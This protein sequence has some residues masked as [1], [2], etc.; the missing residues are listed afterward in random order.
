MIHTI[1]LTREAVAVTYKLDVAIGVEKS[2]HFLFSSLKE[3]SLL[4][5]RYFYLRFVMIMKFILTIS[6]NSL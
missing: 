5:I 6:K 4:L 3:L 1:L 2:N